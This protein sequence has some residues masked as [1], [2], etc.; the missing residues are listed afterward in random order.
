MF[1]PPG[2]TFPAKIDMS[3]NPQVVLYPRKSC[4]TTTPP[5]KTTKDWLA[6]IIH[7]DQPWFR[8]ILGSHK[9]MVAYQGLSRLNQVFETFSGEPKSGNRWWVDCR[10]QLCPKVGPETGKT[11]RPCNHRK[12]HIIG[13]QQVF[14]NSRSTLIAGTRKG[15][16]TL[17][18]EV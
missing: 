11:W 10:P 17:E 8:M 12:A 7:Q 13:V 5:K 4:W 18:F 3:G 1:T 6:V 14:S 15:G 9:P 2:S 16:K